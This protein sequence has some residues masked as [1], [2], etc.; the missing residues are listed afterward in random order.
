[1]ADTTVNYDELRF[2]INENGGTDAYFF[3]RA[4]HDVP[5]FVPGWHFKQFPASVPAEEIIRQSFLGHDSPMSWERRDPPAMGAKPIFNPQ[6]CVPVPAELL[7]QWRSSFTAWD[8]TGSNEMADQITGY[9][10]RAPDWDRACP[11]CRAHNLIA[12]KIKGQQG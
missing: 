3:L 5:F 12:Q 6:D 9:L 2:V 1:M 4:E 8:T 7:Q 11:F 10:T